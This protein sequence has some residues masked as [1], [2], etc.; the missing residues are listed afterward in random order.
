MLKSIACIATT[1]NG[2]HVPTPSLDPDRYCLLRV[3]IHHSLKMA[4]NH[5]IP[6]TLYSSQNWQLSNVPQIFNLEDLWTSRV[7]SSMLFPDGLQDDAAAL[8]QFLTCNSEEVVQ[9][10]DDILFSNPARDQ[11]FDR[12]LSHIRAWHF[13]DPHSPDNSSPDSK[14]NTS[15]L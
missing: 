10:I 1:N 6:S 5:R 8:A 12:A 2:R 15:S 4:D 14:G 13:I 7:P 9:F 3:A 11:S